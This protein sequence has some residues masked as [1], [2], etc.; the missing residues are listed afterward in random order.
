MR[1]AIFSADPACHRFIK[2]L[3][4]KW[5]QKGFKTELYT[6]YSPKE[7][8]IYWFDFV[9][10][11]LKIAS[12]EFKDDL[13][14]KIVIARLHYIEY[15][16]GHH[17]GVN[18]RAVDH[19]I[20]VSDFM[21]NLIG[22]LPV[23]KHTIYNGID[24]EKFT[25]KK[26]QAG[27]TLGYA[28][29]IIPQKGIITMFHYFRQ[30]LNKDP[31][32]RLKMV[33]LRRFHKKFGEYYD[34]YLEIADLKDKI[35]EGGETEDM[36]EWLEGIDFLWQPSMAESFSMIIG[37]AM[38]KGIKPIINNFKVSEE[39]WLKDLIYR[40]FDEFYKILTG[41]YESE[42]YRKHIE[43]NYSLVNITEKTIGLFNEGTKD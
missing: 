18:W 3:I 21:K 10:N 33:G 40:D 32:Y 7:A 28:G 19:L 43:D 34:H 29:H 35:D 8:D 26:R 38:A 2:P 30:L 37:E 20:L 16:V 25:Y 6:N 27:F 13:K 5:Q 4:E 1:I 31:R 12:S 9:D 11:N 14:D 17:Y 42:R 22:D 39:L 36:N 41:S 24:L 23:K 15:Y